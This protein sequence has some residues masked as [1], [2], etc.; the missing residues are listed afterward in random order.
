MLQAGL[1]NGLGLGMRAG[2]TKAWTGGENEK[3]LFDKISAMRAETLSASSV[4]S[5]SRKQTSQLTSNQQVF[6]V[7]QNSELVRLHCLRK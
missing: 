4:R 7:V 2:F 6:V 3:A 1:N 5:V